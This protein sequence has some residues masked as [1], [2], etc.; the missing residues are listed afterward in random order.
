VLFNSYTFIFGFLPLAVL[1]FALCTRFQTRQPAMVFLVAASLFF[2]AWWDWH[3]L[4]LLLFSIF[5]NYAWGLLLHRRAVAV[6]GRVTTA[7][8]ILLSIGVA[9]DLG[10]L[11]YFKYTDFFID[12]GNVVFGAHWELRHITLP[13]AVS[14]FTFEQITYLVDAYFGA[15]REHTFLDYGV[16]ITLFPRLLAGPITRPREILPQI[17]RASTYAISV[18]NLN[19]GL[20]IF[21][22]G[23]FKKVMLADTFSPMVGRIFEHVGPVSFSDAWGATLAFAVQV[24]FDFSGYSDM[25]IGLALLFNMRLPE[26]FNSPY[27]ARS[28]IDFWRRWHM[29]LSTFLR[30][31]LYIPLGG[32]RRGRRRQYLNLM[33]TMSLC[34]LWHGSTWTFVIFGALH[35]LY[36]TI[37][38]LWQR[39]GFKLPDVA[40]WAL[41]FV[42]MLFSWVLFRAQTLGA[43]HHIFA[44]ML[45]LTG[46]AWH[47]FSYSLGGKEYRL[48]V[49]ALCVTLF[50]PNRQAIMQWE[51]TS[52]R[53]YAIVF[54]L[55]VALPLLRLG[56]SAPFVYF[57]F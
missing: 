43:A 52:D 14:F 3:Y 32:N 8:R 34:G 1:G 27:K 2:Y 55:L 46:F 45:G 25:A 22:I 53:V 5:F 20:F 31:Y 17:T 26:N 19:T 18:A 50:F 11:G 41:T 4:F 23:L 6:A 44:G 15:P 51:W 47:P 40:A 28:M 33:I 30:D 9:V 16:F 12:T 48:I 38:H 36:L 10:L 13:L 37:N 39:S 35:G 56:D 24:Y 21:A 49:G 29:T 42:A 7:R 54:T 57:Q